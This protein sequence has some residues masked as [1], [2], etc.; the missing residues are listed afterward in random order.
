MLQLQQMHL[1]QL[2]L[3]ALLAAASCKANPPVACKPNATNAF[4]PM[5]SEI[6]DWLTG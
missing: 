6:V 5:P 4:C 1:L 2:H 3:L